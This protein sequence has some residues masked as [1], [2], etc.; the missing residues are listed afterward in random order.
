MTDDLV[1]PTIP[2]GYVV[3]IASRCPSRAIARA[4]AACSVAPRTLR[5]PRFRL[6]I[7]QFV[8][9]HTAL[10]RELDDEMFGYFPRPVPRG[11]YATLVRM[12]TGSADVRAMLES[13]NRFYRL[14]DRHD[15][16]QLE[17]ARGRATLMLH[18]RQ[19]W[20][21]RSIFFVHSMLL[22]SWRTAAWLVGQA[23]PLEEVVLPSRFR[24]LGGETRYL[25]GREPTFAPGPPRLAFRAELTSLPILRRPDE[26]DG[27]VKT[28]LRDLLLA[29]PRPSLHDA[30]RA[31]LAAATPF[32]DLGVGE[33]A[34]RLGRSRATLARQLAALGTSFQQIKDELRRDHA[35]ALLADSTLGLPEIAERLGYSAASAFQRAFRDWTGVA[36]GALR[37]RSR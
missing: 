23:I 29:P 30:L 2:I 24:R 4:L 32:A 10:S 21:E 27:Y 33:A 35:I 36:P 13:A 22:A 34:R 28:S 26:A 25:F 17:I 1:R 19:A 37:T 3:E 31:V 14:F 9:F 11:A 5:A 7:A 12:L 16:L 6:S 20:Q 8:R 15:Y 18:A